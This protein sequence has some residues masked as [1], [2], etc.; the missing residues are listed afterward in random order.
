MGLTSG[1]NI[2]LWTA[3]SDSQRTSKTEIGPCSSPE[4]CWMHQHSRR[5][6]TRSRNR[7]SAREALL[8]PRIGCCERRWQG[9]TRCPEWP[10]A[11]LRG[12]GQAR[13]RGLKPQGARLNAGNRSSVAMRIRGLSD[14]PNSTEEGRR[15]GIDQ[16]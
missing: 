1:T 2:S 3:A 8:Y 16:G 9:E 11:E 6:L 7:A 15:A 10:V 5:S 12:Y 14:G 13:H 4:R